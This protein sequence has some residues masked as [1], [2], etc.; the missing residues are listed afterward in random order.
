[1]SGGS[2]ISLK[3]M[4]DGIIDA[5][6]AVFLLEVRRLNE[7]LRIPKI[8]VEKPRKRR[9]R[10]LVFL[11]FVFFITV[12]IILFFRSSLSRIT[13]IVVEGNELVPAEQIELTAG[14]VAGDQF[15]GVSVPE[16]IDRV[17]TM[18]MIRSAEVT[19]RFPGKLLIHVQ[20]EPKVAFQ[21]DAEGRQEYVLADGS[22]SPVQG[23]SVM[24]D[25]P[26]LSGWSD[27]DSYKTQLCKIMSEVSESLFYEV[28]EII[29]I[30][31][32]SYPDRIKLY[33]RKGFEV[34]TTIEYL[35]DK[36]QYL[37]AFMDNLLDNG[38]DSGV[39]TLLEVDSH[40]ALNDSEDEQST[41]EN[42]Q[43]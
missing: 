31:S 24:I 3:L 7:P 42:G 16:V 12:L 23:L 10:K 6:N 40:H 34:I 41:G 38:V 9:G 20:E 19:K 15:F 5:G 33:T 11:L 13:E 22:T 36:I 4:Y 30:P 14:I 17:E 35:P 26:I 25:M 21:F 32:E 18:R 1:M 39:L 27:S 43:Q 37:S 8:P 29:P 28:S 2:W